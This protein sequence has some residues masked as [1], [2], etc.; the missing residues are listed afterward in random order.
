MKTN[1]ISPF[2]PWT[3]CC[4]VIGTSAADTQRLLPFQGR[5]T[6]PQGNP[7]PDGPALI[8]FQAFESATGGRPIW[9]GE[10][11][12]VTVNQGLI[13]V[14]LGTKN[15]F[16]HTRTNEQGAVSSFFDSTLFLEITPDTSGRPDGTADGVITKTD[17][18]MMP[19]QALFPVPHAVESTL[20]YHS[21]DSQKLA[22]HDW[23]TL[24][25]SGILDPAS[26]DARLRPSLLSSDIVDAPRIRDGSI[27]QRKLAARP[28]SVDAVSGGIAISLPSGDF[29]TE[30]GDLTWVNVPQLE[31]TLVTEGRPVMLMLQSEEDLGTDESYI[32]GESDTLRQNSFANF[33][34]ECDGNDLG[35]MAFYNGSQGQYLLLPPSTLS[36]VHVVK[37][38]KHLYKLR[39]RSGYP[40]A[41]ARVHRCVL[42][43]FEL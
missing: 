40:G 22:G 10:L 16:P 3:L 24:F 15:E 1:P 39:A 2:I 31:V 13:N 36:H 20:S 29:K 30:V 8:Q 18:P 28:P 26:P 37:P 27:Q 6:G 7:P 17:L 35:T 21:L 38:G 33:A 11:H 42:V 4:F 25:T 41:Y 23:G 12:R 43:A 34:F 32:G 5:I 14:V 19:R 9:P